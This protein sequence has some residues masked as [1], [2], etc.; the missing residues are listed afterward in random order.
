MQASSVAM[1]L[2][3][4]SFAEIKRRSASHSRS[5]SSAE[6]ASDLEDLVRILQRSENHL[7]AS[8]IL[9]GSWHSSQSKAQLLRSSLLSLCRKVLI[10]RDIDIPFAV[11]SL[12]AL[13]YDTMVKELKTAVPSIQS[14][15]SRLQTVALVGEELSHLWDQEQLLV[16][17]QG[18]QA[19]AKWWHILSS[20][21]LKFDLRVFQ[22]PDKELRDTVVRSLIPELFEKGNM[23]LE[24]VTEYCR[25]FDLEPEHATLTYV[26]L[27]FT[28]R[29]TVVND[30]SWAGK[31]RSA[32]VHVNDRAML[33]RLREVLPR[34]HPLDY[35]KVRYVCT[36]LIDLLSAE[37][38]PE[39]Q[40]HSLCQEDHEDLTNS[41]SLKSK[42]QKVS[43]A[44]L[45]AERG[46]SHELETYR[47]YLEIAGYLAGL[48]FPTEATA[49]I[50]ITALPSPYDS[51]NASYRERIPLWQLLEEPWSVLDPLLTHV[52]ESAG[53][54]APLCLPLRL[55]KADFNFRK[56]MAL[57]A[58]MTNKIDVDSVTAKA[59]S[60]QA[61]LSVSIREGKRA[62]LQATSEAIDASLTN[63][64]QQLKLWQWV[65]D[66][67]VANGD[68]EHAMLALKAAFGVAVNH[69][70]LVAPRESFGASA[71]EDSEGSTV[72]ARLSNEMRALKCKLTVKQFNLSLT[73]SAGAGQVL[74]G[75]ISDP[76]LLLRC[77]F[78]TVIEISWDMY[79]RGLQQLG[80]PV[81]AYTLSESSPNQQLLEFVS[82]ATKAIEE[83]AQHCGQN[84]PV[85]NGDSQSQTTYLELSRHNMIGKM[86]SD[87]ETSAQGGA[88]GDRD[89][90]TASTAG[91][92]AAGQAAA[93]KGF[94]G[95]AD[96]A[97]YSPS[98]AEQRRREDV[99][100]ALSISVLVLTCAS[101]AQR[102][103]YFAQLDSVI[104][105]KGVRVMRRL[106]A[107]SKY[108]AAQ[109]LFY[110]QS[111]TLNSA[112]AMTELTS[113]KSYLYCLS[114]LQ[115]IRLPCTEES[116]LD[117]MGLKIVDFKMTTVAACGEP[118]AADP[119]ALVRTWIH[120]EGAHTEVV[121]L[122]RDLL[123]TTRYQDAGI[124]FHLVG[125]MVAKGMH[126]ALLQ[127]LLMVRGA[128]VFA[129]MCFGMLGSD[130]V[131]S[132]AKVCADA[133]A[134]AE[135]VLQL[136]EARSG[137]TVRQS[138]DWLWINQQ[139]VASVL[140]PASTPTGAP[141]SS[142]AASST[143]AKEG[144]ASHHR[145]LLLPRLA[146]R[147]GD[148]EEGAPEDLLPTLDQS[149]ALS[150]AVLH[151]VSSRVRAKC[152]PATASLRTSCTQML[153]LAVQA[154]SSDR[155]TGARNVEA[156]VA[157][158]LKQSSTALL[159]P[160]VFGNP[161]EVN[162]PNADLVEAVN[163][164][165]SA[166]RGD[167]TKVAAFACAAL[168]EL[169]NKFD[170]SVVVSALDKHLRSKVR[171]QNCSF[172]FFDFSCCSMTFLH[173]RATPWMSSG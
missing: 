155:V 59:P 121:E 35:E 46:S 153:A 40:D 79:V 84:Q 158:A 134:R 166:K 22:S 4:Y 114:E 24:M 49:A 8:R 30:F 61:E 41:F 31:V 137:E 112:A 108:R 65:Y 107:R 11:A 103:A 16:L 18:L 29:P 131:A 104:R 6:T 14:D 141:S 144:V 100:L 70:T 81:T 123:V 129:D 91:L 34:V 27:L 165:F 88:A 98:S 99:F 86:L 151:Q 21:G 23:D 122:A 167:Y 3:K 148:W 10:Y 128:A 96:E 95:G 157:Q 161:K 116:L 73:D 118:S 111:A 64:L 36:W 164:L 80:A 76:A 7:L 51:V 173:D 54:L 94:W 15:F 130:I 170:T 143:T 147:P 33:Q 2:M 47:R 71:A 78:E 142:T 156:A 55:D 42:A 17:F 102:Q 19:N 67:E 85:Q 63:P 28:A 162:A 66:R 68:D 32:A 38:V 50:Q 110:L 101:T 154:L 69:P 43:T 13:T 127:S 140:T 1:P 26:D 77:M 97:T 93:K 172:F 56:I 58:R 25:Q 171:E 132:L 37:E 160:V 60:G 90:S 9:L 52:P 133:T 72:H 120:D 115:E 136:A 109:S 74:L 39:D 62:A 124:W 145:V 149:V 87:V 105:G 57:Y 146:G 44:A 169:S 92:F 20:L 150:V 159:T 126:R 89:A 83:V 119:K 138:S 48:K 163:G 152:D 168:S 125:H 106:T 53:K 113:Y 45:Q 82:T 5:A 135:Q 139:G 12:A 75:V 117:A